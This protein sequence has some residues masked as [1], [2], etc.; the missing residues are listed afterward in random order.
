MQ[1]KELKEI[2]ISAIALAIAFAIAFGDG[3]RVFYNVESLL[4]LFVTALVSVSLGFILHEMGHRY[5]ARKYGCYA[6]FR[7]WLPGLLIAL[8]LSL[9]GFVFAAPGAVVIHPRAD[10]WGKRQDITKKQLGI[11]AAAGPVI[12]LALAAGFV[13]AS[14]FFMPEQMLFAA[15]VNVWLGLFNM[16]PFPP[17]DGQKIFSWDKRIWLALAAVLGIGLML[18]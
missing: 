15:Q 14:F 16:I 12:N 13:A 10:L 17:L 8:G 4:P 2:F 6:E 3:Y 7:M 5:F 18:I 9:T 11:V 1:H